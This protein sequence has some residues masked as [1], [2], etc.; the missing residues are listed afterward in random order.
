MGLLLID[1]ATNFWFGGCYTRLTYRLSSLSLSVAICLLPIIAAAADCSKDLGNKD[2]ERAVASCTSAAETGDA[3][4]QIN[5]G[6]MY[7]EGLGVKKNFHKSMSLYR[8][9]AAQGSEIA[10][11][12]IAFLYQRGQG[13][14]IDNVSAMVWFLVAAH[15]DNELAQ[16]IGDGITSQMTAEEVDRAQIRAQKCLG[17]NFIEC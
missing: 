10:P 12:L 1:V 3:S 17:S 4:A 11:L 16:I 6:M 9:A 2:Y 7:N 5:L 8:D 13:V 14:T 15:K